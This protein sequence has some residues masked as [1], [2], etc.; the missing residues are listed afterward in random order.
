MTRMARGV[1]KSNCVDGGSADANDPNIAMDTYTTRADGKPD[2]N[3]VDMGYHYSEAVARYELAVTL[4][5]ANG[6]FNTYTYTQFAGATFTLTAIPDSNYYIDSWYD[7]NGVVA[8]VKKVFEVVMDANRA[9]TLRFKPRRTTEVSGGGS[10]LRDAVEEAG[11]GDILIVEKGYTYDGDI[12]L[13][14]K[15]ITIVSS[16]PDDPTVV[17]T[18]VIDCQGSS[19]AFTFASGEGPG[20]V[21]RGFTI[22]N[23][24]LQSQSGGAIYIGSGCSPTLADL[25]IRNSSTGSGRGG[26]IYIGTGSDPNLFNI[27]IDNCTAGNGGG[28]IYVNAG[29]SPVFNDCRIS[30]CSVGIGY[31]GGIYFA[32]D[33]NAILNGCEFTGNRADYGGAIYFHIN[34]V[35]Q[36][37][38]CTFTNNSS[39]YGGAIYYYLGCVS[40]VADCTFTGN[41]AN[42]DGGGIDCEPNGVVTVSDCNFTNN[43]ADSG[44]ALYL[45]ENCSGTV[46]GSVLVNN[47]ANEDG[48]A[49]YITD[50]NIA[51]AGCNISNNSAAHGAGVYCLYSPESS[52]VD[53]TISHNDAFGTHIWYEYFLRDPNN[54]SQPNDPNNPVD[55]SDPNFDP[56]DPNLLPVRHQEPNRP[57]QGGGIYAFAGPQLIKDCDISYNTA[58]TSGGGLYLVGNEDFESEAYTELNN[59]L[60]TNNRAGI[61][62]AG[63]SCN[64]FLEAKISNC[65]IADN[66]LT[67]IPAYGGGLYCSYA[68]TVDVIDSI[69]WGNVGV[70]GSQV[71]I[72]DDL[73]FPLP[74]TVSITNS[75][76]GCPNEVEGSAGLDIAFCIDTT[77]SMGGEI[78]AVKTSMTEIVEQIAAKSPDYRIAVVDYRDFNVPTYGNPDIDYPYHDDLVFETD[79]DTIIAGV[80]SVSLGAGADFYESVLA[81]LMHCIDH[82][83]LMEAIEPNFYG[84]DPNDKGPG[85]WRAD[86]SRV[87]ILLGDA[88]A[89]RPPSD[90]CEPFTGYMIEDVVAAAVEKEI[91]IFT[92]PV[93]DWYETLEDFNSIAEGTGGVML[94]AADSSEVVDA[95]MAAIEL[96]EP[97]PSIPVYVEEGCQL[98]PSDPNNQWDPNSESWGPNST[99]ISENP[100]FVTRCSWLVTI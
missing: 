65:T 66:Q 93:R 49:I 96:I 60:V 8:S 13:E 4:A 95:I 76:V 70:N 10:A 30:N 97:M 37:T 63:I 27:A 53:C 51:V 15:E 12:D 72:E 38:D 84:A 6:T 100:L 90:P 85:E 28:A 34:C 23:G 32:H 46:A 79:L 14:G 22:T 69:I 82:Q 67:Q 52:I 92:V 44:G 9:Y 50:S 91:T 81:G 54:P 26:G 89:H 5:D 87:I 78:E 99:N 75:D 64:W 35:S 16:K 42:E 94:E 73:R 7:A 68:S 56:N 20:T 55:T 86:A 39:D 71:A 21:I 77:S 61:D 98:N 1:P 36:L 43:S 11:N 57:G 2:A 83:A 47:D 24:G 58:R 74:S 18:T 40:G 17:A 88:A 41:R 62:G 29:S 3:I 31:G 48:G 33:C 59:C 19:R 45:D 80:N 25:I